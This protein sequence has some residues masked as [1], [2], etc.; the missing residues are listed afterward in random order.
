VGAQG[1]CVGSVVQWCQNGQLLTYD[2]ALDGQ[3]C[4]WLATYGKYGCASVSCGGIGAEGKCEGTVLKTCTTL[5][6]LSVDCA[7]EGKTCGWDPALAK[8]SCIGSCG[9][10][11]YLGECDGDT[12]YYCSGGVDLVEVDCAAFGKTCGF[13][14]EAVGYDCIA[15]CG[16]VTEYGECKGDVL[17]YCDPFGPGGPV[18]VEEDCAVL[19]LQCGLKDP[20][21][22]YG[23]IQGG[24]VGAHKVYGQV[25]FDKATPTVNGLGAIVKTTAKQ[26]HLSV[27]DTK[28]TAGN[29]ADDVLLASGS[30]D[31]NGNYSIS[32]NGGVTQAYAVAY[33]WFDDG[34]S[35]HDVRIPDGGYYGSWSTFSVASSSFT[36]AQSVSLP[37]HVTKAAYSGAFNITETLRLGRVFAGANIGQPPDLPVHWD[38]KDTSCWYMGYYDPWEMYIYL[39]S[40]PE[41]TEEF[42]DS[43]ILHEFGHHVTNTLSQDD[44][45]GGA[46][47]FTWPNDPNLAWSEGFATFFGQT[48]IGSSIYIDTQVWDASSIDIEKASADCPAASYLGLTQ[49]ICEALVCGVLWDISDQASD[50][51]DSLSMGP[52]EIHDVVGNYFTGPSF[53]DRGEPGVDFVEFLDGWFC[54]GHEKYSDLYNLVVTGTKFPYD[55]AGPCNKPVSPVRPTMAAAEIAPG[56]YQLTISVHSVIDA[57]GVMLGLHLPATVSAVHLD[58]EAPFSLASGETRDFTALVSAHEQ[59]ALVGV[60]AVYEPRPLVRYVGSGHVYL[61]APKQV[62]ERETWRGVRPDGKP[63]IV[64]ALD[65]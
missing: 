18:V 5:G 29:K 21:T 24:P 3:V 63:A 57:K 59:G 37:I 15:S 55:F 51:N 39:A 23:C 11:T 1:K 56:L 17:V 42:D 8:Y 48:V 28:G 20:V 7:D 33:A 40:C 32:F 4:Q 2:C 34:E 62:Q 30:T 43:V 19:G 58:A 25:T 53:K 49:D 38:Y 22:G 31:M 47:W 60:T 61:G 35:S 6:L 52:D 27:M 45:P 10:V 14:S 64:H 54:L 26:I 9:S 46:H 16:D 12:L 50:A 65:P 13:V 41:D 44:N 36:P